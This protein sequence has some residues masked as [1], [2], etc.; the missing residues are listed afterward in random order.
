MLSVPAIV[1]GYIYVGLANSLQA[2]GGNGGALHRF[3]IQTGNIVASFQLG[4]GQ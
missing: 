2:P 1:D 3:D 4:S